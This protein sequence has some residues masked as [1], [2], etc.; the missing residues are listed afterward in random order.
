MAETKK[1]V[2][3]H[4]LDVFWDGA[5]KY[6]D[7]ADEVVTSHT[8]GLNTAMDTRVKA[9]EGIDHEAYKAADATLKKELLAKI[10]DNAAADALLQTAVATNTGDIKSI[11]DELNSL[12]GGAGS[13]ATQIDNAIAK[14]D[15]P[16]TYEA[17]GE[18]A[19]AETAAK[20]YADD[21]AA[22]YDA[23][24]AASAA[25][26]AAKAYADGLNTTMS[27]RVDALEAQDKYVAADVTAAINKAQEDA[28]SYAD[29]LNTTMSGRVDKLEDINHEAIAAQAAAKAV[30]AVVANAPEDLNTLKEVADYIAADKTKASEI[31]TAISNLSQEDSKIREDFA[32]ADAQ[33]LADAKADAA[34]L[35]Q[36]KGDY[37]KAGTAAA[38]IEA[39]KLDETY[40]TKGAAA[41][42][43]D[44][45]KADATTKAND[46]KEA[47][48]AAAADDA[49]SK[50]N[51]AQAA[52]EA[53]AT[54]D[55]TS[56][57]NAAQA[58]AQSY[59]DGLATNYDAAG[60][61]AA[62]AADA[63]KYTDDTIAAFEF[64]SDAEIDAIFVA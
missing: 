27:G 14:L 54:A 60:A 30:A 2:D 58:A 44:A 35:Y 61:A 15:L 52:A 3:L 23:A 19:K 63:K 1:F 26:T 4:G 37:E 7:A 20:A 62:A 17:K 42:A 39:L 40:E 53:T 41:D 31:E 12:S 48:I 57:A 46:A 47:A 38:A 55:A 45:A 32:A 22:N 5:K 59:A 16:N 8:D 51:A 13:I 24:G 50:A 56:K 49:T 29:G 36:V 21:L 33:V 9:L 28:Q 25:E 10:A 6:I 43:L 18:A 64:A 11:Q 34:E